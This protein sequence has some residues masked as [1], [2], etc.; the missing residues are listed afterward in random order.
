MLV[1]INQPENI[2]IEEFL[3][4]VNELNFRFYVSEIQ[5]MLG[6][7]SLA[8]M[9]EAVRRAMNVCRGQ[10]LPLQEHFKPV[11]RCEEKK[12]ILDWRLS[13]FGYCLVLVNSDPA[14]PA[15]GHFQ[16]SL[17]QKRPG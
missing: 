17:L 6:Y 8:E 15:V 12:V 1:Q 11:Y 16:I 14:H 3:Q 13:E 7:T 10:R 4:S 2:Y 9:D 5:Q